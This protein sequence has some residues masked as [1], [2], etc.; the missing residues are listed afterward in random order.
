MRLAAALLV[1]LSLA[2]FG[3]A[4]YLPYGW[5][6]ALYLGTVAWSVTVLVL[7][8]ALLEVRRADAAA[9]VRAGVCAGAGAGALLVSFFGLPGSVPEPPFADLL[10]SATRVGALGLAFGALVVGIA[11]I[12]IDRRWPNVL[13]GLGMVVALVALRGWLHHRVG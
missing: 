4:A 11:A 5:Q 8:C 3:G 10:L 6:T 1:L 12:K 9:W 13:A 2:L 7:L